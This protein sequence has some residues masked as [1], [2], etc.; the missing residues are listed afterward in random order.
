MKRRIHAVAAMIVIG[1][2]LAAG[3]GPKGRIKGEGEGSLVGARTAGAATYNQLV[4]QSVEKLLAQL[5]FKP[6]NDLAD[7]RR[8]QA[9]IIRRLPERTMLGHGQE[10]G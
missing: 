7:Q 9:Q 4:L 6:R 1:A 5:L 3:C 10:H 8:G 2:I